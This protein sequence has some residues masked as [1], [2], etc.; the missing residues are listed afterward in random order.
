[1]DARAKQFRQELDNKCE[2]IRMVKQEVSMKLVN[3]E[4]LKFCA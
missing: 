3:A 2:A 1:M 4:R